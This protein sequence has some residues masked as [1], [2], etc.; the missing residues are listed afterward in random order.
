MDILLGLAVLP[1]IVLG[2][3]IYKK[4]NNKEPEGLLTKIFL[5][6]VLTCVPVV[7]C[8]MIAGNFFDTD[9]STIGFIP[10]FIN[11]FFGVGLIEEF[12]KW[13]VTK[14]VGYNSKEYD[15]VYDIIVYS[16]FASLGFACLENILY[17]FSNGIGTAIMRALLSVPG[18]ACFGVIMGY[19]L[20]KAKL[21]ELHGNHATSK[22]NLIL[23]IVMPS[24]V[25][26]M[27]D[28]LLFDGGDMNIL[29]F[30]VFDIIM[31]IYCFSLVKRM[32][33]IQY[34]V[35]L[36]TGQSM[37]S[38]AVKEQVQ[39]QDNTKNMI[40]VCPICKRKYMKGSSCPSCG[41]KN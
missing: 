23:S 16:V 11:V 3:Y 12:F 10:M 21:N 8:E 18:H 36:L 30:F 1:V 35:S 26:T 25:H 28:A 9:D 29:I 37:T 13:L 17:V 31:V 34:N 6:G 20:S 4:D 19:F 2:F 7:I 27:Y 5:L 33:S 41:Y 38:S 24:L 15:E 14:K 22:T 40:Q 32:S 39:V